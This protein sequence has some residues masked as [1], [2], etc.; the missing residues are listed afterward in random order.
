M[1]LEG[2]IDIFIWKERNEKDTYSVFNYFS[3]IIWFKSILICIWCNAESPL[4]INQKGPGFT[5]NTVTSDFIKPNDVKTSV[6]IFDL[7]W[8]SNL[9]LTKNSI[10]F[11]F[12]DYVS[13]LSIEEIS[14][15]IMNAYQIS[16]AIGGS[17]KAFSCL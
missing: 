6:S 10:N 16:A 1:L 17:Y 4:E 15:E 13:A 3:S 7:N 12:S 14:Q 5:I 8:L 2:V 9:D 11:S